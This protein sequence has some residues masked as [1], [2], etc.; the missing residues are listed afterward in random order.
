MINIKLLYLPTHFYRTW[1]DTNYS[2]VILYS[3]Y[4]IRTLVR[5]NNLYLGKKVW[6]STVGKT[7]KL[8]FEMYSFLVLFNFSYN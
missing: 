4:I 1:T 3:I 8:H 5:Y 2:K 6:K 7:D